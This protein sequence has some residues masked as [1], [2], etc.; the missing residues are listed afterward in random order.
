MNGTHMSTIGVI[1][2]KP[3]SRAHIC[4]S[5]SVRM[6]SVRTRTKSCVETNRVMQ[7]AIA[8]LGRPQPDREAQAPGHP[9]LELAS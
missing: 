6:H 8:T 2:L 9:G 7:Q 5:L 1:S 3:R 4:F